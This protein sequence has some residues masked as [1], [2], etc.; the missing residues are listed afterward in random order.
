MTVEGEERVTADDR[1]GAMG[2]GEHGARRPA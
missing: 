2:G 1:R